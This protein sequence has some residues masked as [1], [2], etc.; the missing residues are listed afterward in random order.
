MAFVL[1]GAELG[2][3]LIAATAV[4][5]AAGLAAAFLL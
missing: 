2:K 5:L 4:A 1:G 3:K